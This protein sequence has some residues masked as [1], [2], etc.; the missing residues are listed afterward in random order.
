[1]RALSWE[2][3]SEP[4][5]AAADRQFMLGPSLLI[6][7]VLEQGADT[8]KGVFP[9]IVGTTGMRKKKREHER[10]LTP[11]LTRHLVTI[12]YPSSSE[13]AA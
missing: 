7:S 6:T 1:M 12:T 2:F 8:V 4:R 10:V 3:P 13:A 5:L 11:P 9:G